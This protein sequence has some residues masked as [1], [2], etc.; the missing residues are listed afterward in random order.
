MGRVITP[1]QSTARRRAGAAAV[2]AAVVMPLLVFLAIGA[3]D[4]GR[5]CYAYVAVATAARNGAEY[6]SKS[7]TAAL[8]T[9]GIANAAKAEMT[10]V[11]GYSPMNPA[12][13]STRVWEGANDYSCKVTVSF[14]FR[15]IVGYPGLA[16]SLTLLRTVHMRVRPA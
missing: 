6:G 16:E 2:E 4:F 11:Y 5:F 9:M 13:T 8:D 7:T 12:V 10:S 15:T 14:Q 1:N 3:T